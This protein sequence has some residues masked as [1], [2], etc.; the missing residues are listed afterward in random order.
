MLKSGLL[1]LCL[2]LKTIALPTIQCFASI[3]QVGPIEIDDCAEI[4][5]LMQEGDKTWAPMHFS[6]DP[7]HGYEVPHRWHKNSCTVLIDFVKDEDE[8]TF[9]LGD[10]VQVASDILRNCV[11]NKAM[12]GLGGKAMVGPAEK[13]LLVLSGKMA[14]A[15]GFMILS[16]ARN[17]T[18]S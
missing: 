12:P 3:L 17:V 6:R 1:A 18:A 11:M 16:S 2:C 14:K 13:M 4:F 9:S 8:D 10:I 5:D 7:A 15:P